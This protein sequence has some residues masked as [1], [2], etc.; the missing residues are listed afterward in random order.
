M[1]PLAGWAFVPQAPHL[2]HLVIEKIKEPVGLEVKQSKTVFD[3]ELSDEERVTL[4]EKLIYFFPDRF[5]SEITSGNVSGFSVESGQRFIKVSDGWT[6]SRNKA[7]IDIYTDVLLLR[8]YETLEKRLFKNGVNTAAVSFERYQGT[9]CYVIG[10]PQEDKDQPFASLW[11]EK[12]TLLPIRYVV[13]KNDWIVQ[14][15]YSR[16]EKI[17]KTWYPMH[18]SIFVDGQL[19]AS[20]DVTDIVLQS[21]FPLSQFDIDQIFRM[22]PEYNPDMVN[23]EAQQVKELE[24]HIEDFKKLYE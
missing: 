19:F 11:I 4:E 22:Y 13:E 21:D 20:I 23:E 7:P 18:V 8:N 15:L 17:S 2:L 14:C 24:K 1:Q 5:R 6:I 12:D 10:G 16:W 9:I 3:H